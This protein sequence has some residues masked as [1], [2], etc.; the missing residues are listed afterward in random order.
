M[1]DLE[2]V[3]RILV[4][5]SQA[6]NQ[7]KK[8]NQNTEAMRNQFNRLGSVAK[9]AF[10]GLVGGLTVG[11]F[12]GD[13]N[14]AIDSMDRITKE[15]QKLGTTSEELTKF[16]YAAELSGV[17]AGTLS[18]SLNLLSKAMSDLSVGKSN[19]ATR[20]LS[21]FGISVT[22]ANGGLRDSTDVL[23][24]LAERFQQMP[25]GAQKSAAALKI[26]GRSGAQLIPLLN[27]GAE[28][29]QSMGAE[30][31]ALGLVFDGP[32]GR[33]SEHFNDNL[34]RIRKQADGVFLKM[35]Q[36]LL[37]ALVS[38]TDEMTA[39][40][41]AT[42]DFINVG[43]KLGQFISVIT[44]GF[45][46]F[47]N[48]ISN[49]YETLVAF[50]KSIGALVAGGF[51]GTITSLVQSAA[52][53][54]LQQLP[55]FLDEVWTEAA[56][57]IEENNKDINKA[58]EFTLKTIELDAVRAVDELRKRFRDKPVEI[59][60]E[61]S[62]DEGPTADDYSSNKLDKYFANLQ[63]QAEALT[64]AVQ[65][66]EETLRE[67]LRTI[68]QLQSAGYL[69][70]E[71]TVLR[72]TTQAWIEYGDELEKAK[73][74]N[75]DTAEST[76][77]MTDRIGESI[78]GWASRSTEAFL[79]FTQSSKNAFGDL[80]T[81][82][83]NDLARMAVQTQIIEP[84]F[85]S[86]GFTK[87]AQGNVF[88]TGGLVPFANGGIVNGPTV[89]PFANGVGLMGEA[90]PEAIVP[91]TRMN[92]GKLGVESDGGGTTVNIINNSGTDAKVTESKTA[93]GGKR[94]DV[95][96]ESAIDSAIGRGRFDKT[97]QTAFNIRRRGA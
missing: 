13:I 59:N 23:K 22:D 9:G 16:Q 75:E 18:N 17:E 65:T 3:Y 97:L 61:L 90:G 44:G 69:Q 47:Y 20:A 56:K 93:T 10:A 62:I 86:F 51:D 31:E 48:L 74:N 2:R 41:G 39:T 54:K 5:G 37:P 80:A 87:N 72:A 88:G 14:K 45:R 4:D 40:S 96:I 52:S 38:I 25:D 8:I 84:L 89:F 83:L 34:T 26:F 77:T 27:Q 68:E 49:S 92:N 57:N 30:A 50:S 36:G 15:A 35:T 58:W 60:A 6:V 67:R 94:I 19:D 71:E 32:L 55:G 82:I 63:K 85:A 11:K 12:V 64:K 78:D 24:D 7:L 33:A 29:L 21:E 46:V 79:D 91:L 43:F 70:D 73:Q 95:M 81:S 53:G 42:V 66:P 1:A 28:G 76:K